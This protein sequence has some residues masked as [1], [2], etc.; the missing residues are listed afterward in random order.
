[1]KSKQ[2]ILIL[3]IIA[4]GGCKFKEN[5]SKKIME[6]RFKGYQEIITDAKSIPEILPE[7]SL[8]K[9]TIPDD[10]RGHTINVDEMLDSV[11]YVKLETTDSCLIGRIDRLLFADN[12]I[13]VV[14]KTQ[15]NSLLLFS[16]DGKFI[17]QVG[18]SGQGPEEYIA[19]RDVA[20]DYENKHVIVLDDH[21]KKM[22]YYDLNGNYLKSQRLIYWP[23]KFAVLTD[24]NILFEQRRNV[25]SHIPPICDN[26]LLFAEYTSLNI[27]G[28]TL[29]YTYRDKYKNNE[30]QSN[31]NLN[32]AGSTVLYNP[33]F[34]DTIYEIKSVNRLVAKYVIDMGNKNITSAFNVN[35]TIDDVMALMITDRYFYCPY[36]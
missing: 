15:R 5:S 19:I 36:Q 34:T 6:E 21:G 10:F 17:S 8:T 20:V 35:T 23:Y 16:M 22:L 9:I 14:E 11:F 24:G 27:T 13:V 4:F 33:Y 29:S 31:T 32:M 28:K 1:M 12:R 25:N 26:I 3:I 18:Q 2:T 7:K 30:L